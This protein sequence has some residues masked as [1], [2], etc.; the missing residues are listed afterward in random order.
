[1]QITRLKQATT[2]KG[3]YWL[4]GPRSPG[5]LQAHLSPGVRRMLC[6]H[7][8]S[9]LLLTARQP[10]SF[11]PTSNSCLNGAGK[12]GHR[13]LHFSSMKIPEEKNVSSLNSGAEKKP[14]WGSL[15]HVLTS[16]PIT[17]SGGSTSL[18]GQNWVIWPAQGFGDTPPKLHEL[19]TKKFPKGRKPGKTNNKSTTVWSLASQVPDTKR[20]AQSCYLKYRR[21]LKS[22]RTGFKFQLW[23]L[24]AVWP[25]ANYFIFQCLSFLLIKCG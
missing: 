20:E 18:I 3:M 10:R 7:H 2:T 24:L 16:E 21:A 8:H 11:S 5:T 4:T 25:Q 12:D 19:G 14:D 6:S 1:M 13:E 17:C 23:H 22:D 15:G 9:P